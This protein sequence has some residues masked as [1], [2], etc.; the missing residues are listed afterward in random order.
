MT[1]PGRNVD[2][3]RPATVVA[4]VVALTLGSV[5]GCASSTGPSQAEYVAAADEVCQSVDDRLADLEETYEEDLRGGDD[6]A[7]DAAPAVDPRPERWVR[8]RV[9]PQYKRLDGGLRGITPPG[10]DARYLADVYDDLTA[11]IAELN[12]RPGQGRDLIREDEELRTRF[13]TY[14]MKVCGR[15]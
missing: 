15:V 4:L 13:S 9:I 2:A 5:A 11:L 12:L 10:D 6:A 3:T 8:A 1:R 7:S 14:G